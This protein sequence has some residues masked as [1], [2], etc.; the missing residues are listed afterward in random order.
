MECVLNIHDF[1]KLMIERGASDLHIT[2]GSRPKLRIVDRLV[3]IE[4]CTPLT[5]DNTRELCYSILSDLQKNK[6]EENNELDLSFSIK[7]LS[8]FRANIFM[9]RGAVAGAFRAVPFDIKSFRDLGLPDMISD[10]I[11]KPHGLL[12]IT[13]PA[14][15]GKSTTLASI[16]DTINSEREAHIVTVEDPIE[17]IHNHKKCII[18]QREVN[19]DTP[20][21]KSALTNI[22]RQDPDIVFISELRDSDTIEAAL[23][24]AETGH[25]TLATLHTNSAI[26]TINRITEAFPPHQQEQLRVQLSSVIEGIISQRLIPRLDGNGRVL[27]IEIL[28]MTPAV[29]SLIREG[30]L[31]QLCSVMQAGQ[32]R[33]GMQTMNQSLHD[34]FSKGLISSEDAINYSPLPHEMAQILEKGPV[35]CSQKKTK[36]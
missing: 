31:N 10:L 3:P 6:F 12:L 14:G 21:F 11:K 8:R 27:A 28:L 33:S 29:R 20:S 2:T 25:F 1:L 23:T 17:F 16:I 22:M 32:G 5:P 24:L 4:D 26:Q 13:G 18:N 34:L 30:K 15:S 35:S 36:G 7:G 9:Q 19:S